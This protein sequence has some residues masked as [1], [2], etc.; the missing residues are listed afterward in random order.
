MYI[1][2]KGRITVLVKQQNGVKIPVATLNDGDCFGELSIYDNTKIHTKNET[3]PSATTHEVVDVRRRGG[4]CYCFED[5]F[6]MRIADTKARDILQPENS[7]RT[8]RPRSNRSNRSQSS[9]SSRINTQDS[10]L[11]SPKVG[12]DIGLKIDF[13][14][15]TFA[16][17]R[18]SFLSTVS[19]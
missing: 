10:R 4:T 19:E 8:N 11:M 3:S 15:S 6:M 9:V 14:Q 2:L 5:S 13:L 12:D 16:F 7:R 17:F 1:I 18:V